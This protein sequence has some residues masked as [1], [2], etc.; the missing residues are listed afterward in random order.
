MAKKTKRIKHAKYTK[1]TIFLDILLVTLLPLAVTFL[2]G[3]AVIGNIA[4]RM[5]ADAA[6]EI[7]QSFASSASK[8]VR[9]AFS[10]VAYQLDFISGSV[11]RIIADEDAPREAVL[12]A[13]ARL[14]MN[15]NRDLYCA[16]FVIEPGWILEDRRY[17]KAYLR[18]DDAIE[19]IPP[20]PD[21]IL[22]DSELSPWYN[23]P[24]RTRAPYLESVDYF[25]YGL[26]GEASY[27][28]SI[29]HPVFTG[30]ELVGCFGA[31]V[32]YANVFHF[33]DY[34]QIPGRR[35]IML[36]ADDGKIFYSTNDELKGL[37]LSDLDFRT[38]EREHL[39]SS[40]K[41]NTPSALELHSPF[42]AERAMVY[43]SPVGLENSNRQLY[44]Y[45][46]LPLSAL[47]AEAFSFV[48]ASA[49]VSGLC[50]TLAAAGI[51][52]ATLKVVRPIKVIIENAN[53]IAEG[54]LGVDL[55]TG[56]KQVKEPGERARHEV[57][58]LREALGKMV[59]QLRQARVFKLAAIESDWQKRRME[60]AAK[61]QTRFF[62][63]MSHE[64]RTPMNAILGISE[65]LLADPMDEMQKR[66]VKDI[67]MSTEA[68]LGI[69]NDILDLSKL[70]SGVFSLVEVHYDF[71]AMIENICS[72]GLFLAKEKGL[73]FELVKTDDM[74]TYLYG[75]DMRL[76]QVLLNMLSN[77]VKYT[78]QG[79]VRLLI[80]SE[81]NVLRFDFMDSGIGIRKEDQRELFNAF[82]QF[83]EERNR[84]IG[85]TGLGLSI[86]MYLVKA[87]GGSIS[88]ESVYGEGST[89]SV[90]VPLT[91]GDPKQLAER[92]KKPENFI[93]PSA[94]VL[95]VDDN[96]VN[97]NVA[98]GLIGLYD[99]KCDTATSGAGAVSILERSNDYDMIFMDHM[100]PEMDGIEASALIRGLGGR[101]GL[102]PIVALTAN[103]VVEARELLL[104]SGMDD[105]LAKPL[106][107]AKLQQLLFKWLPREKL[108]VRNGA[109][110][111]SREG[112][113]GVSEILR[114]AGEIEGLDV[115]GGLNRV[116]MQEAVYEKSL[117]LMKERIPIFVQTLG[118]ACANKNML[119]LKTELHGIKGALANIGMGE[120]SAMAAAMERACISEDVEFYEAGLVIFSERLML[121]AE[122]LNDIFSAVSEPRTQ[123]R[124]EDLERL[125]ADLMAVRAALCAFNYEAS[126]QIL[127]PLLRVDFGDVV[128]ADLKELS[129]RIDH[130][131]YEGAIGFLHDRGFGK[132]RTT[133]GSSE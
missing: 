40:M 42:L 65:L 27:L 126:L 18:I 21:E 132:E 31:D 12:E 78:E 120:L 29:A 124:P 122:R 104:S 94:K 99:I 44:M 24:L 39:L 97:L 64:I 37:T 125:E 3:I 119:R 69:I 109:K 19:E 67:K 88:M 116:S 110:S 133:A 11:G 101:C 105:F 30:G 68:L 25:A 7:S 20:A 4:F 90:R 81:E 13:L 85:G 91:P 130:F 49:I 92:N 127:S 121:F 131:D 8:E 118:E 41:E 26:A 80:A 117:W 108:I 111:H 62:A 46:E 55:D 23:E 73:D 74:P 60:S 72:L 16:W 38:T 51:F 43:L 32:L 10:T 48:H 98:A 103:A 113:K 75:D 83:D 95:V 52:W 100:M 107:R 36:V 57:D 129:E 9:D 76:R 93:A 77:A 56:L 79:F 89:F 15:Y 106:E 22:D 128:N 35:R 47:Y 70:E 63:N 86:S 6:R 82:K 33:I 84:K 14:M 2:I 115:S 34:W 50:L 54:E 58:L 71:T 45:M 114:L 5:G 59:E 1:S 96:E 112:S 66:Y 53:R 87:M 102:V 28:G 61:A 17:A 123:P